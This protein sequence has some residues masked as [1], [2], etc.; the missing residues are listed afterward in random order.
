MRGEWGRDKTVNETVETFFQSLSDWDE[1]ENGRDEWME[2]KNLAGNIF[3][4]RKNARERER[5]DNNT[6]VTLSTLY[7]PYYLM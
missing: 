5:T 2:F 7:S 6:D 4:L 1:R 3:L